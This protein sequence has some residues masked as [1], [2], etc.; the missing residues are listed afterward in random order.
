MKRNPDV[1]TLE[2]FRRAQHWN[3]A[4]LF[5]VVRVIQALHPP[6]RRV[7]SP[8]SHRAQQLYRRLVT[9]LGKE[10]CAVCTQEPP[11]VHL[12]IA[13]KHGKLMPKEPRVN[14]L[15]LLCQKHANEYSNQ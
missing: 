14:Q 13:T 12:Q 15:R 5:A 11:I 2:Q 8:S 3:R 9:Y 7:M 4:K 10:C 1:R 6:K